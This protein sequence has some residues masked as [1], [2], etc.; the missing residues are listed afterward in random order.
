M[1]LLV[2]SRRTPRP[3]GEVSRC[4]R[5][6]RS[7]TAPVAPCVSRT[8]ETSSCVRFHRRPKTLTTSGN[9]VRRAI[10]IEIRTC[11]AL[12]FSFL[13]FGE[14]CSQRR[15]QAKRKKLE[16]KNERKREKGKRIAAKERRKRTRKEEFA[17]EDASRD[18]FKSRGIGNVW[19]FGV[20]RSVDVERLCSR[21]GVGGVVGGVVGGG[22]DGCCVNVS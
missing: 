11:C 17:V 13:D 6:R 20:R 7:S 21:S 5:R 18:G 15:R 14:S 1:R 10:D 19:R 12:R 9:G 22:V 8:R 3:E 4:D 2:A 16:R